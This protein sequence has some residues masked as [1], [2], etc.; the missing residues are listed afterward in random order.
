MVV[1]GIDTSTNISSIAWGKYSQVWEGGRNQ[2]KD[3]L[4]KIE[5]LRK[6]TGGLWRDLTGVVVING[7]G[8]YTGIR[9]GVSVANTVGM[10]M[11]VP[12]KGVDGLAGQVNL[13]T[14][15]ITGN[16]ISLIGAGS[17]RVYARTYKVDGKEIKP[18]DDYYVGDL[19]EYTDNKDKSSWMVV[20]GEE[21]IVNWLKSS[22]W[23]NM[24]EVNTDMQGG[25]AKKAVELCD[26][27]GEVKND[28]VV[29]MYLRGP[30]KK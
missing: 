4:P 11:D 19:G 24:I 7:P 28:V 14:K 29:P 15:R 8:S 20:D 22:G 9:I 12:V 5:K 27:L 16:I 18:M 1:L 23:V 26:R 10:L 13:I 25:R 2:S 17:Q 30:I 3:L 21:E 6:K